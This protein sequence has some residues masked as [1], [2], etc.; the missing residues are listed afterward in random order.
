MRTSTPLIA[1]SLVTLLVAGAC[2]SKA[3][4]PSTTGAPPPTTA[5]AL[6]V[7]VIDIGRTLNADKTIGDKTGTFKPTDTIYVSVG[8]NG[9]SSGATLN[10]RFT[11]GS[12]SQLVKEESRQIAPSGAATTEFH[13]AKPDGWPEG[14]YKVEVSLN[15]APAG[16]KSFEVKK[17]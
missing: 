17:G 14:E 11:Y 2:R 8:T 9:A 3:D 1:L 12:D 15:G 6:A 16:T 10:A 5:P 7:S 4:S 13:I